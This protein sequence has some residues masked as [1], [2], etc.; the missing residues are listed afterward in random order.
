MQ[1]R[2]NSTNRK[3]IN[4]VYEKVDSRKCKFQKKREEDWM[5]APITFPLIPFYDV[6]DEPLIIKAK[7]EGYLVQIVFSDQGAAV[8]VMFEHFFRK[9]CPTI[10]ARLTHTH[11]ELVGVFGEQL[12]LIGKIELEVMFESEV[13]CRRTMIKFTVVKVPSSYNIITGRTGMRELRAISSTTHAMMKFPTPRGIATLVPRI[14]AIFECMKLEGKQVLPKEQPK[15]G[16]MESGESSIEEDI[17]INP[18][19]LDQKV[20]IRT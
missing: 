4:M 7:V 10:Q 2:N 14:A 18:K 1:T 19:F 8:Q 13:L 16:A 17:M 5:N 12:L 3:I 20:T 6:S 11:T 9:L 15:E